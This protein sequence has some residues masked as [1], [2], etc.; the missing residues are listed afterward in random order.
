MT[1]RRVLGAAILTACL[2]AL[3]ACQPMLF[4]ND[5]RVEIAVPAD[6]SVVHPPVLIRWSAPDFSTPANGRFAV[7]V[8][9]D[10]M[11]PGETV[12]Y[13]AGAGLRNV[14][15]VTSTHLLLLKLDPNPGASDIERNHHDVTVVLLDAT[16]HRIG[17]SAGFAEFTVAA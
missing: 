9:R 10:P 13:F 7:F 2:G 8:D 14:Y 5:H 1:L 16:G 4:R 15:I 3:P 11:P 12:A 6:F 17:E